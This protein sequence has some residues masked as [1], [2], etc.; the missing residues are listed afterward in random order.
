M[1]ALSMFAL[2][3]CCGCQWVEPF[4]VT[5]FPPNVK[6]TEATF[7][8]AG[9]S[10][11]LASFRCV[12]DSDETLAEAAP[13]STIKYSLRLD[14]RKMASGDARPVAF[15][16]ADGTSGVILEVPVSWERLLEF[17][18]SIV[19]AAG[20]PRF[21]LKAEMDVSG[22]NSEEVHTFPLSSRIY[23]RAEGTVPIR[24]VLESLGAYPP[25]QKLVEALDARR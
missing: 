7:T 9:R 19:A 22:P 4:S 10:G 6:M 15:L 18:E 16:A 20:N 13:L 25:A 24:K 11:L 14:R 17:E 21:L 3:L 8:T 5:S 1:R 23:I 12:V 2:T